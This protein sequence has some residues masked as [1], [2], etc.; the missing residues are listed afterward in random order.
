MNTLDH[1]LRHKIVAIIR[2]VDPLFIGN[3]ADAL[4]E[5]GI[6]VLEVTLN[7]QDAL[8]QI[9][10]LSESSRDGML[11]GA[12]T[13]LST[14]DAKLARKAGAKFIISPGLDTD[15]VKYSKD[16]GLVSIPG[17][18]TPTEIMKADRAGADIVKVFPVAN[19]EYL[20]SVH[21][22]LNLIRLMPTGGITAENL[23]EFSK[24]GAVAYGIGSGLVARTAVIDDIY[25]KRITEKARAFVT[26]AAS[27]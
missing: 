9:K 5:G 12:G 27:L 2:G 1:I 13:V 16:H 14:S 18:Y 23:H 21:A 3:I 15:V 25:L 10:E 4:Y 22:P 7:T 26:T 6:R 19:S 20:K 8:R 11:V 17:A 24:A